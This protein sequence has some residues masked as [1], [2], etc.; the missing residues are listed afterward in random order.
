MTSLDVLSRIKIYG[1]N[2]NC[3]DISNCDK[4]Y[5]WYQDTYNTKI[6]KITTIVPK[7]N[8][9]IQ[10][11]IDS[12]VNGVNDGIIDI[13]QPATM[14]KSLE[15]HTQKIN[16]GWIPEKYYHNHIFDDHYVQIQANMKICNKLWCDYVVFVKNGNQVYI[17]RIYFNEPYWNQVWSTL[18]DYINN[19]LV[20]TLN[21]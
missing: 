16:Q 15:H 1:S 8:D 6:V 5:K 4:A 17:E 10:T 13:R 20:P 18:D 9:R 11:T 21:A 7:W 3:I 14:Y 19:V 2:T 12:I